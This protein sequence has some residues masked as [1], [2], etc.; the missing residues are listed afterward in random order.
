MG[1]TWT[2]RGSF[3]LESP[4]GQPVLANG[5]STGLLWVTHGLP[6]DQPW[7]SRGSVS[8]GT[9]QKHSKIVHD[10][11]EQLISRQSTIVICGSPAVGH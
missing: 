9:A 4:G 11:I 8:H 6:A 3:N 10:V 1:Q 5:L 2:T 7:L